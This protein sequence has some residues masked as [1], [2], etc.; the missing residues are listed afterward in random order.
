M[1]T[2]R[3]IGLI[4]GLQAAIIFAAEEASPQAEGSPHSEDSSHS[5]EASHGE[6]STPS[7]EHTHAIEPT[8][9]VEGETSHQDS[10]TPSHEETPS[11]AT[12]GESSQQA[13]GSSHSVEDNRQGSDTGYPRSDRNNMGNADP[14]SSSPARADSSSTETLTPTP[15]Q[16]TLNQPLPPQAS[17]P[18]EEPRQYLFSGQS[19]EKLP[20]PEQ[21]QWSWPARTN[22][23]FIERVDRLYRQATELAMS[24]DPMAAERRYLELLSLEVP[25]LFRQRLLL[26]MAEMY[27]RLDIKPKVA[28]V[29]E[30]FIQEF[31]RTENIPEI[32]LRL[33]YLYREMGL[34]RQALARFYNVLNAS[35]N[36]SEGEL[37]RYRE[38]S[39][40]AQFEIAETHYM[41][42]QFAQASRFFDRLLELKLPPHR[43]HEAQFRSAY[44]RYLLDD[45]GG[46]RVRLEAFLRNNEDH[47]L[48]AEARYLLANAHKRL[49]QPR[50]AIAVTLAL[51]RHESTRENAAEGNWLF[52]KKRTGNQ[53][54][55]EFYE[56]GDYHG[57]LRIY[58]AMAPLSDTPSWQ[59]PVIY[60][61]GLCFERLGMTPRAR[62]AYTFIIDAP[63]EPTQLTESLTAIQEMAEWRREQLMWLSQSEPRLQR[64]L[65]TPT[66]PGP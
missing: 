5:E 34:H 36:V 23:L 38:L 62:D 35:L 44:A 33:G 19:G 2:L 65:A 10:A 48:A 9:H 29:Y 40:R 39:L 8:T 60:Q 37:H 64:F 53:L 17:P 42:G 63:V 58:Q 25:E 28:A 14:E 32:Q 26:E 11:H 54:A 66:S 50:E 15:S 18:R 59:W 6:E 30:K 41:E 13:E 12:E 52:W 43:R 57:A 45:F 16:S 21:D 27:D 47:A 46:A 3:L 49:N 24:R 61:I 20:M 51:L 7:G 4:L 22:P 31:P 1:N 55:N 56:Q